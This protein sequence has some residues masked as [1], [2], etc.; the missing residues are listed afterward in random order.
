MET[1]FQTFFKPNIK[2]RNIRL[3]LKKKCLERIQGLSLKSTDCN[4]KTLDLLVS[5][6]VTVRIHHELKNI[7]EEIKNQSRQRKR[8]QANVVHE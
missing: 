8:K 5:I 6:F 7:N 2:M 3:F 4:C 1:V